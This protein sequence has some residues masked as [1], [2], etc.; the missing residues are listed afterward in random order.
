MT[1]LTQKEADLREMASKEIVLCPSKVWDSR[2]GNITG[3]RVA[4]PIIDALHAEIAELRAEM[5]RREDNET[6]NCINWGPCS[7]NDG[8]MSEGSILAKHRSAA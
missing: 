3:N 8:R 4:L 2:N 5:K 1:D 6:R 7:F